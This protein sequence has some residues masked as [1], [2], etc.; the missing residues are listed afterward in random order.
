MVTNVNNAPTGVVN[1]SGVATE[2]TTLN[3]SNT[4]VDLDGLGSITYQWNRDI[5]PIATGDTYTLVQA[6][7]GATITV[8]AS[9]TDA[10]GTAESVTS[11]S[12]GPIVNVNDTPIGAPVITGIAAEDQTL[13]ANI[14]GISDAGGLRWW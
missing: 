6:D 3:A 11:A 4:L 12:V 5:T 10:Q 2:G 14:S 1:I 8:I 9:Y 7:V 13:T